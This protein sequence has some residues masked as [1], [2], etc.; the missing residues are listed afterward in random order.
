[1]SA[2][3]IRTAY[4]HA[5]QRSASRRPAVTWSWERPPRRHCGSF[6][7]SAMHGTTGIRLFAECIMVCRVFF[8]ALGKEAR[9]AWHYRNPALC[10][11]SNGLPSVFFSTRQRASLPSAKEKTLGKKKTL[12]KVPSLPSVFLALGKVPSLQRVFFFYT[13]QRK[14]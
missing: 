14:F 6:F 11:V 12:G 2:S 10:R 13:R 7:A 3:S 4:V 1:M 8:L 9:H 5:L